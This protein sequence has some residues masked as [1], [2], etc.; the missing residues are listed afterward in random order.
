M[1]LLLPCLTPGETRQTN[2]WPALIFSH[3]FRIANRRQDGSFCRVTSPRSLVPNPGLS[4][5]S[6]PGA[7]AASPDP[8]SPPA[9]AP[10]PAQLSPGQPRVIPDPPNFKA[11]DCGIPK[12]WYTG[13]CARLVPGRGGS[14]LQSVSGEPLWLRCRRV[15]VD[16]RLA[17]TGKCII[18]R[19][20][21]CFR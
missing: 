9:E 20:F 6:T 3:L 2:F 17:E 19:L 1:L 5:Q 15:L 21:W 13:K 8:H 16:G 12:E 10:Q 14:S 11:G 18:R 7:E 4:R